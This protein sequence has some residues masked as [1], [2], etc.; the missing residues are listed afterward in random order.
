MCQRPVDSR[1]SSVPSAKGVA[2][3]V[4]DLS[5]AALFARA[6]A[7]VRDDDPSGRVAHLVALHERPT[8]EVFDTA[9][10]LTG[11]ADPQRRQLG[12]RVLRELGLSRSRYGPLRD[13][14]I[15]HLTRLLHRETDLTVL[16]WVISALGYRS[17]HQALTDV[18]CY[19]GHPDQAVRFH[20]AAALPAPLRR[21][22]GLGRHRVVPA[23]RVVRRCSGN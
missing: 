2:V 18:L 17:A 13:E 6:L 15:A 20:V 16:P 10:G 11:S 1:D 14:T 12:V 21:L 5:T 8:R 22:G 19:A 3:A 23:S 9:V 7:E 4:Q